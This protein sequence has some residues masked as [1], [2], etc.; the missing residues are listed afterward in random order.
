MIWLSQKIRGLMKNPA[1]L[2]VLD[3]TF[4]RDKEITGSCEILLDALS[5]AIHLA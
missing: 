3:G 1:E 2:P 4:G 5:L